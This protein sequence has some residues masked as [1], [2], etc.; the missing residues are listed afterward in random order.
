MTGSGASEEMMETADLVTEMRKVKHPF[1]IGV[2]ARKG[3]E[4]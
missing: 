4:Y 3:I 2:G 1:D